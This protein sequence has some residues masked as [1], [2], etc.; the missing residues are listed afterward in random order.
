MRQKETFFFK[1]PYILIGIC[2]LTYLF[3]SNSLNN[4]FAIDDSIIIESL[5]GKSEMPDLWHLFLEPFNRIDYRPIAIFSFGLENHIFGVINPRISHAINMILYACTAIVIFFTI[6]KLPISNKQL[7]ALLTSFIFISLPVHSSVVNNLKSRDGLFSMFFSVLVMHQI[8]SYFQNYKIRYLF[9]AICFTVL[10]YIS[11]RD[12]LGLMFLIPIS[13]FYFFPIQ[14][15]KK[16]IL[17][18]LLPIITITIS[19][20]L[21]SQFVAFEHSNDAQAILFTENPLIQ[22]N[23]YFSRTIASIVIFWKY[24]VFM[25]KPYGYYFYFGYNTV[26][27]PTFF[28]IENLFYLSIH[29]FALFAIIYYFKKDKLLS[30]SILFFYTSLLYC[31]GIVTLVGGIIADRYAYI[32]SLGF[33]IFIAEIIL[34]IVSHQ[35]VLQFFKNINEEFPTIQEIK[36]EYVAIGFTFLLILFYLPFTRVRNADWQTMETLLEAD[37]PH[38]KQSFEANRIAAS[39]YIEMGMQANDTLHDVLF[40][41]AI[42]F[43]QQANRVK[44]DE[45][46]TH[47]SELI[48]MYGMRD[49][50]HAEQKIY[51]IIQT[52]DS[53][54]VAWDLLGDL[55][56]GR[57]QYDSAAICYQRVIQLEPKNNDVFKKFSFALSNSGNI[58]SAFRF[59]KNL[60]E[61]DSTS[62]ISYENIAYLYLQ[63]GD[64]INAIRYFFNAYKRGLKDPIQLPLV[65]RIL[66]KHKMLKEA[67]EAEDLVMH[68]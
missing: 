11:K 66:R 20:I 42:V 12:S 49:T 44:N 29:L 26:H 22:S 17:I 40:K 32:A 15:N 39:Y 1:T 43:A 64:S 45:L 57:K 25:F 21:V 18:L 8:F 58:D 7:I 62:F 65:Q 41:K 53:S 10:A 5:I 19:S 16:W 56:Y 67:Q 38:L 30:Y 9:F 51:S 55:T 3:Y 60:Y 37:M 63:H 50:L 28:S 6:K 23:T 31:S 35:K 59:N 33:C 34:K 48:G 47:E 27:F 4:G 52:F 68:H 46:Y 14:K 36:K 54:T 2:L 13:I 24:I 61:K